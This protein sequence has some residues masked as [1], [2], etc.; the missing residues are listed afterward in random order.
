MCW[1]KIEAQDTPSVFLTVDG[2]QAGGWRSTSEGSQGTNKNMSVA[3]DKATELGGYI[4]GIR[5]VFTPAPTRMSRND[6]SG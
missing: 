5:R 4:M 1:A 6:H 2:V 3:F